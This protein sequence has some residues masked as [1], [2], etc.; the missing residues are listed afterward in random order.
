MFALILYDL[1][2][3]ENSWFGF[4]SIVLKEWGTLEGPNPLI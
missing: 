3:P 4:G 1:A 2:E